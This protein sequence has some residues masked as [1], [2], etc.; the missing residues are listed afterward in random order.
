LIITKIGM[1]NDALLIEEQ[2]DI[3]IE[4]QIMLLSIVQKLYIIL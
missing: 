4:I 2:I 3:F 1:Y